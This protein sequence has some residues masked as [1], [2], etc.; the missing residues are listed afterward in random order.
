MIEVI[1]LSGNAPHVPPRGTIGS[2]NGPLQ[3][4]TLTAD[5]DTPPLR[6]TGKF[7]IDVAGDLGGGSLSIMRSFD[8]GLIWAITSRDSAGNPATYTS[9]FNFAVIEPNNA[10][11]YKL[12]LSGATAPAVTTRIQS[13]PRDR[14]GN[15]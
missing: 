15:A 5:G 3:T 6:I 4:A 10:A 7:N 9:T 12:R 14:Y 8:S 2:P 1:D 11:L 13:S